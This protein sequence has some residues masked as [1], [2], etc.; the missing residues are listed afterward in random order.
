MSDFQPSERLAYACSPDR[1]AGVQSAQVRWLAP[2]AD[3]YRYEHMLL[4]RGVAPPSYAE[5]TEWHA[6]GYGFAAYLVSGTVIS[7]AAVLRQ[8]ESDWELAG[9]R[10]L[11]S[12]Q[13]RG[14]ATAVASFLTGYILAE[15]GR[16]I[17]H[18]DSED[19]AM[20]HILTKLGYERV[21]EPS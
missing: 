1:F 21:T 5:W 18:L 11:D 7:V 4:T 16:A 17:C 19:A 6:N 13:R 10:T 8:P 15:K 20:R 9:V 12:H 3:F 14:Y 2:R